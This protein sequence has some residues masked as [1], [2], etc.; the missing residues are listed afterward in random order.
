LPADGD[1]TGSSEFEARAV[2]RTE[3]IT[4]YLEKRFAPPPPDERLRLD[5]EPKTGED[6]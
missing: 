6:R 3:D 4:A 1:E 2:V 5:D